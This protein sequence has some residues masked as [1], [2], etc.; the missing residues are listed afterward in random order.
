MDSGFAIHFFVFNSQ[1][2]ESRIPI[3]FT[4]SGPCYLHCCPFTC[5]TAIVYILCIFVSSLNRKL[6]ETIFACFFL[7]A[8]KSR[9][10]QVWPNHPED[11]LRTLHRHKNVSLAPNVGHIFASSH[12]RSAVQ[13]GGPAHN[14]SGQRLPPAGA[15]RKPQLQRAADRRP[16]TTLQRT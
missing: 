6:P 4:L 16:S 13:H 15:L 3:R 1:N 11:Y 12:F 14:P 7:L 8:P 2:N 9:A 10:T 5:I